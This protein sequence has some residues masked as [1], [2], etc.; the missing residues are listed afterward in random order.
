MARFP[1][2]QFLLAS[3]GLLVA[4]RARAEQ[5]KKVYHV[6]FI[7]HVSPLSVMQGPEPPHPITRAFIQELRN[8]G[9]V[10]GRNL[11][12]ERRTARGHPERYVEIFAELEQ[13][14]T[15]VIVALGGQEPFKRASDA[16]S[17]IPVVMFAG[18]LP[19]KYGLA[20]SLAHP[21]GNVT[22]LLYWVGPE[23]EAKRL[24]LFKEAIP[25]LARLSYL[26]PKG[27][28]EDPAVV[29]VRDAADKL[30][31]E[32]LLAE[33]TPP[34]P[35]AGFAAIEAQKPDGLFISP[36]PSLYAYRRKVVQ[37]ARMARLAD[38]Y[39]H[40]EFASLGGLM[41]YAVDTPDLGRRAA[42]YVDRILKGAKAGD[43][44]IEQPTKFQFVVNS[45]TADDLGLSISASILASADRV[46]D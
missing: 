2:R 1:R 14:G 31:I 35:D 17:P 23:I 15:Q 42:H 29:A 27:R 28:R 41:S 11:V 8:L 10:E 18:S 34:D 16:V 3:A 20:K 6:A 19:V 7:L 38:C 30:G 24:Q 32:L 45:K 44:P 33:Y 13:A 26:G 22:G 5:D 39:P 4:P 37:F 43:L 40:P 21:G 36:F 12:L 25:S 9:Y 46:I